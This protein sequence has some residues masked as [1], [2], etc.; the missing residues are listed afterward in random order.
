MAGGIR[1][2]DAAD[3]Y[4]H[5]SALDKGAVFILH[6]ALDCGEGVAKQYVDLRHC[7][8]AFIADRHK[9]D[10]GPDG[11]YQPL[12]VYGNDVGVAG[13]I[14]AAES[15]GGDI[16]LRAVGKKSGDGDLGG[17]ADLGQSGDSRHGEDFAGARKRR[18]AP[19]QVQLADEKVLVVDYLEEARAPVA[20]LAAVGADRMQAHQIQSGGNVID[21][22]FSTNPNL[23]GLAVDSDQAG[24]VELGMANTWFKKEVKK[25]HKAL[26]PRVSTIGSKSC[27]IF[28]SHRFYLGIG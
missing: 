28:S 10:A 21:A 25:K 20:G 14:G 16:L 19:D 26:S 4:H 13:G 27:A 15:A 23:H 9:P 6:K 8:C 12:L 5:F 2:V 24:F 22:I 11:S 7:R 18:G 3:I 17:L 1:D